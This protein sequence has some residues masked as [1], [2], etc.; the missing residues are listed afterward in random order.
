MTRNITLSVDEDVLT[1]VKAVAAQRGT[2]VNALVRD[3]LGA[4]A[5][6]ESIVDEAR[7]RLL[8]LAREKAGDMGSRSWKR[9]DLYDR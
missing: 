5:E 6:K 2:S 9:E 8:E 3:Y 1:K 7:S 4:L